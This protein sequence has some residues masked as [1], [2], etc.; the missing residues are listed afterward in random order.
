MLLTAALPLA[1]PEKLKGSSGDE[2]VTKDLLQ[3]IL[4]AHFQGAELLE[5]V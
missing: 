5:L 3:D 2:A 4:T 1:H